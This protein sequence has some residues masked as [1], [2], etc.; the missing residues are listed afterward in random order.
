MRKAETEPQERKRKVESL[1][2]IFRIRH[3]KTCFI[4]DLF[5][6]WKAISRELYE[7]C[8]AEC[9]VDRNL[10]AK[11]KKQGYKSL[12]YPRC[13]QTRNTNFGTNCICQWKWAGSLST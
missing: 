12:Y 13:I 11:W 10:M 6:K 8:T 7:Y 1:W 4:L 5:Y 3:Q 2:S 9:S